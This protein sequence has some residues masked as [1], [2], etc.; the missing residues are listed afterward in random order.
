MSVS[1]SQTTLV[2]NEEES[3]T[4]CEVAR[5]QFKK[6]RESFPVDAEICSEFGHPSA[7]HSGD[8]CTEFPHSFEQMLV[9]SGVVT[10]DQVF[11]TGLGGIFGCDGVPHRVHVAVDQ[12][13]F[14]QCVLRSFFDAEA[15]APP[16]QLTSTQSEVS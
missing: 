4:Y 6:W 8:R 9:G 14:G 12:F 13:R 5:L 3:R 15:D 2:L 10:G 11:E 1:N 16:A 7:D